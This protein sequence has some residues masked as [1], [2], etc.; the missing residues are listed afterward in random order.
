[1][2][3]VMMMLAMLA[4]ATERTDIAAALSQVILLLDFRKGYDTVAREFV[5]LALLKFG[6]S[7]E[8][9]DMIHC[10]TTAR[11]LVNGELSQ[12]QEVGSGIK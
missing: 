1:M 11:V 10:G 2:K 9:V 12:I 8:F 3:T 6:F 7:Q 5:F 4:T